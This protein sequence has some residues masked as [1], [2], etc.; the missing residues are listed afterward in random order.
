MYINND[1]IILEPVWDGIPNG[2]IFGVDVRDFYQISITAYNSFIKINNFN[3]DM[4][5]GEA[6]ELY[7]NG[8]NYYD[9]RR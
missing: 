5:V 8:G 6:K 9:K 1:N 3:F 7:K 4:G 2:G